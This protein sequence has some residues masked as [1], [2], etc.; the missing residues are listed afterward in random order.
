MLSQNCIIGAEMPAKAEELIKIAKRLEEAP[1]PW[2]T[3]GTRMSKG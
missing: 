2:A 1:R 3:T